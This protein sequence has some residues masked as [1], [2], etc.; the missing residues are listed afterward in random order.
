M[1][2][3]YSHNGLAEHVDM[4]LEEKHQ[5][6]GCVCCTQVKQDKIRAEGRL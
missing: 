3:V 6:S 4:T 2:Y 1:F 5:D